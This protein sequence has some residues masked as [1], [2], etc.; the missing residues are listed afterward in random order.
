M[1]ALDLNYWNQTEDFVR[2]FH[3]KGYED[4]YFQQMYRAIVIVNVK[5]CYPCWIGPKSRGGGHYG[6]AVLIVEEGEKVP[7]GNPNTELRSIGRINGYECYRFHN[8]GPGP[9]EGYGEMRQYLWNGN[10]NRASVI[11]FAA[12]Q[13]KKLN[14]ITSGMITAEL[15]NY[16]NF[17]VKKP[18]PGN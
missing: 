13:W 12:S 10:D 4:P 9:N 11:I 15:D 2:N 8:A 3:D 6:G 1:C 5:E 17:A 18:Q 7:Q 14:A 16:P